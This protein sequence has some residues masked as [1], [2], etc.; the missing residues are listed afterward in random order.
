MAAPQRSAKKRPTVSSIKKLAAEIAGSH[1]MDTDLVKAVIHA[2]SS[3]NP[4][5]VSRCG[6][7]GLMQLMP[8]TAEQYGV[9]DATDPSEN[10]RGG[11]LH[12]KYLLGVFDNDISLAL[13]AYNAGV[14]TVRKYQGIPPYPETQAYVKKVLKLRRSYNG[15]IALNS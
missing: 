3:F 15:T 4:S 2:E 11:V 1:D 13:A 12:L 6:A 7:T 10:I 8:Y 14:S 5:A 9:R